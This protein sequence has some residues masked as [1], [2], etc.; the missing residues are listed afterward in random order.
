MKMINFMVALFLLLFASCATYQQ[1]DNDDDFTFD[2][3]K[4]GWT[5]GAFY[6]LDISTELDSLL[7][8]REVSPRTVAM[9][10]KYL[11]YRRYFDVADTLPP[12]GTLLPNEVTA[13]ADD[14]DFARLIN[15]YPP[16]KRKILLITRNAGIDVFARKSPADTLPQLSYD[17]LYFIKY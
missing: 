6:L 2:S 5:D 16:A 1:A 3:D 10:N 14:A 7:D 17:F 4:P 11:D 13:T 12:T 15:P 8:R 9:Y